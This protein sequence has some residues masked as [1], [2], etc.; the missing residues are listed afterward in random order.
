MTGKRVPARSPN[1]ISQTK[2]LP[3]PS[4][5][6]LRDST[7]AQRS[8]VWRSAFPENLPTYPLLTSVTLITPR[9]PAIIVMVP[10]SA[11]EG[12][13]ET[14]MAAMAVTETTIIITT[15]T[16]ATVAMEA[17]T[18][19]SPLRILHLPLLPLPSMEKRKMRQPEARLY[20]EVRQAPTEVVTPPHQ[21]RLA[22]A[23][24]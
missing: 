10:C 18:A 6:L 16:E 5:L 20:S 19:R 7:M 22:R 14:T 11:R 1:T 4:S 9:A 12:I 13:S 2:P 23:H 21:G 17:A 8:A 15:T 3:A 24:R